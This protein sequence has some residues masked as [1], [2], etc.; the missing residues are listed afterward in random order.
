MW[1]NAAGD[2]V[3]HMAARY[4]LV[5]VLHDIL[6]VRDEVVVGEEQ[7]VAI[8]I[9]NKTTN[10]RRKKGLESTTSVKITPRKQLWQQGSRR[11]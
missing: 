4:N 6:R 11:N 9:G 8:P 5:D 3:L 10:G 2:G 7:E 1:L